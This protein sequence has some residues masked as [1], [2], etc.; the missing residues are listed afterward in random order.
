MNQCKEDCCFVSADFYRDMRTAGLNG[1]ENTLSRDY[2]LP[3]YLDVRRGYIRQKE[4]SVQGKQVI[5]M[6]NERFAVPEVLFSPADIGIQQM[7]VAECIMHAIGKLDQTCQPDL[8]ANIAL[9]GGNACLPGF[10]RRVH[11]EVR[12]LSDCHMDVN[13]HCSSDPSS[14]AWQG[15]KVLANSPDFA[16]KLISRKEYLEKGSD[17]CNEKFNI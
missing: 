8:L 3:D 15:A 17:F 4:E 7:G 2:I 6:N 16:N 10:K 9:I 11:T 5:R 14:Y 1:P 13:V 12:T